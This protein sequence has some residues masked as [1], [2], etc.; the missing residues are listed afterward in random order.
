[1]QTPVILAP[2]PGPARQGN[3]KEIS[4]LKVE[5][6]EVFQCN[7]RIFLFIFE[8]SPLLI[9]YT[10]FGAFLNDVL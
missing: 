8:L 9:K 6:G 7:F 3:F 1:V 5:A 2:A 4:Y 10:C